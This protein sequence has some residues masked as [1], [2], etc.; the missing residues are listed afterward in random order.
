MGVRKEGSESE[1]A[2]STHIKGCPVCTPSRCGITLQQKNVSPPSSTQPC[3]HALAKLAI[4]PINCQLCIASLAA[5]MHAKKRN[6]P[7]TIRGFVTPPHLA[8]AHIAKK[9][10]VLCTSNPKALCQRIM[11]P[12]SMVS[13]H[14][15]CVRPDLDYSPELAWCPPPFRPAS[16]G[17]SH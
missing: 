17:R 4:T 7:L 14:Q 5:P 16:K 15:P 1:P 11:P 12:R 2:S 10:D 3:S 8:H 6:V 13:T 9:G